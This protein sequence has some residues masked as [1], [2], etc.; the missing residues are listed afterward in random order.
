MK[1]GISQKI[2]L[3]FILLVIIMTVG[4]GTYSVRRER[5]ILLSEFDERARMLLSSVAINSE[6][7]LLVG[8][9]E[10]LDK[11][12]KGI[13]KQ[14]D[15]I[16]YA[17]IDKGGKV[18]LQGGTQKERDVRKYS[19]PILTEHQTGTEEL[20][21]GSKAKVGE[22]IGK[23]S[24]SLSIDSLIQ[25]INEVRKAIGLLVILGIVL[26]A[27]FINLL[28]KFVLDQPINRLMKG[29]E[30]ISGGDLSYKVSLKTQDEI[31]E[32]AFSFNQM[33]GDLRKTTVSI[34]I[35]EEEKKR[36]QDV[37]D[38]SEDWIW[39]VDVQGRY[40]YSS[41]MSEKILG[42]KSEEIIGRYFYD[43]LHPDDR[44]EL[45]RR[46]FEVFAQRTTFKN[47]QKRNIRKD[48]QVVIIETS[49]VPVVDENRRM[50]RY[51][52]LDRDITER[53]KA[54]DEKEAL[55]KELK[56]RQELLNRQKQEVEDSRRAIKNVAED[57]A[58][59]KQVL[60]GQRESLEKINRELDDFTYIVSHDLKEP[61]RSIDAF[62]KFVVDDN[63]DKLDEQGRMYLER[64]RAN[65]TRMQELIEDLLEISRIERK[66]NPI[67]EVEAEELVN[68]AKLRLEYAIKQKDVEII[69]RDKLPKVFCDRVRLTEVF[70]N[71][72]SNAIKFN[73]QPN[74]RVE[75][76]CS[77]K[78]IFYEFYIKDNGPGIEEQYFDKIFEIFQRLGKKEDY[79]GTGAGLTIAKKIVQMHK[80]KIWVESKVGEGST[81]YFTIPKEKEFI[82]GKKKIG[83]ILVEKNLVTEEEV[84]KALE[85][86][87]RR[88]E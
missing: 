68:E 47:F 58:R 74:P 71:L 72:I 85:E 86:Q 18:V 82:L 76:R 49:G 55:I 59:S 70:L 65:T 14:R 42:Y 50:L 64:V 2:I 57:L 87:E 33:T 32:L 41:S 3:L 23:V 54:E 21:L 51:R 53:R 34:K 6:Y 4:I 37:A 35:L 12:G 25:K 45:K 31:G 24:L 79:G 22:E 28:V 48:G 26:A 46:T 27:L 40:V 52:G 66:R 62:S 38:S 30:I 78:G 63:K 44:E 8:D 29:I 15:V 10:A 56:E 17:I 5:T 7:P 81:F 43:F 75:V 13:L 60:E 80:G 77:Q 83:E 84:K 67:E 20:V 1:L 16:F 73:A 69:V 88:G 61:L 11:I 9:I 39:E 36:F 19:S